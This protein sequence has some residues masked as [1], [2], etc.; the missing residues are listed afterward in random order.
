MN[1]TRKQRDELRERCDAVRNGTGAA[2]TLVPG[3]HLTFLSLLDDLLA[4]EKRAEAWEALAR[5]LAAALGARECWCATPPVDGHSHDC[6]CR[7]IAVALAKF[8][9]MEA[10]Q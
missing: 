9:A 6:D 3:V 4:A 7:R 5:E 2:S 8:R 1:T 10:A